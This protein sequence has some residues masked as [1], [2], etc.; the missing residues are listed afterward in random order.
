MS[1]PVLRTVELAASAIRFESARVVPP[2][3]ALR[4]RDL[5]AVF[6]VAF[7]WMVLDCL[8]YF[9]LLVGGV[10]T[11]FGIWI[12]HNLFD[13]KR[14]LFLSLFLLEHNERGLNL[15]Y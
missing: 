12:S 8:G 6:D 5:I 4:P 13:W 15:C 1:A 11:E 7:F 14:L 2:S 3:A 10:P 9:W